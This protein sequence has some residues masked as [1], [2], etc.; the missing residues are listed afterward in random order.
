MVSLFR[1]LT[2]EA[3][4]KG[5]MLSVSQ[6]L[7]SARPYRGEMLS[8]FFSEVPCSGRLEKRFSVLWIA[9][10]DALEGSGRLSGGV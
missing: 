9:P 3:V 1:F 7:F 10:R 8:V 5:E 2:F 6:I 4:E